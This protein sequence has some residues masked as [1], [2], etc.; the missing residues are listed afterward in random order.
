MTDSLS[1]KIRDYLIISILKKEVPEIINS[2]HPLHSP[3]AYSN[4]INGNSSFNKGDYAAASNLLSRAIKADST[5]TFAKIF[6]CFSLG[7][8]GLLDS[9]KRLCAKIYETRDHMTR[10]QELWTNFIYASLFKTPNDEINSLKQLEA[11]DNQ[12]PLNYSNLG[13]NYN[14]L[15]QYDKAIPEYREALELYKKWGTKPINAFCYSGLGYAYHKTGQY[16]K[17]KKLYKKAEKIFPDNPN[18]IYRQA[19]LA[20]T[21]GNTTKANAYIEK[22]KSLRKESSASDAAIAV[23]LAGIYSDADLLDNAEEYY[24]Q[25][26]SLGPENVGIMNTLAYFLIDKDRNIKEGLELTDNVLKSN[27]ENY[28]YLHTKGWG[29]YKLG[30]YQEAKDILQKSWDLRMKNATYNHEAFLHLE[31]ARNAVV[32]QK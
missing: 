10:Q 5:F 25:T 7:N 20:L 13:S 24:R 17:E 22:Y 4:F 1:L 32:G 16:I 21:E 27:P 15:Y 12:V 2:Y 30:K 6:L 14:Q 29:L 19:V 18:I 31:A 28:S 9:A 11:F 26:L 23:N 8:Q 3:E